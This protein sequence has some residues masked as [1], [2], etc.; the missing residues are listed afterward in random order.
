MA[1]MVGERVVGVV[2]K[3]VSTKLMEYFQWRRDLGAYFHREMG[4]AVE[5]GP[6]GCAFI[7]LRLR[8]CYRRAR[9]KKHQAC[10][11]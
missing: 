4:P 10:L 2:S 1:Q 11:P 8:R 5:A 9:T 6:S 3:Y 7:F